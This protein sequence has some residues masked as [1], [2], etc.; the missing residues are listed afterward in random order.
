MLNL[1]YVTI[2]VI[3]A[4][5]QAQEFEEVPI[6]VLSAEVN[7]VADW[8]IG[9]QFNVSILLDEFI[10]PN[11]EILVRAILDPRL[12]PESLGWGEPADDVIV[13]RNGDVIELFFNA[14]STTNEISIFFNAY[15]PNVQ[16]LTPR[17]LTELSVWTRRAARG[18]SSPDAPIR[19]YE[20]C[21]TQ[22]LIAWT[23][24]D[25][26]SVAPRSTEEILDY[27]DRN[28][29]IKVTFFVSPTSWGD[30]F[31]PE[32][33]RVARRMVEEGHEV[34]SHSWS[35]PDFMT[36]TNEEIQEE[37]E[38]TEEFIRACAGTIP[39]QFRPPY[40]SLSK[41]QAEFITGLGY[42]ISLWNLDSFDIENVNEFGTIT[43]GISDGSAIL[44]GNSIVLL[45]H[46][47][48]S[49]DIIGELTQWLQDEYV[50][51]QG[52][53]FTSASECYKNCDT[54]VEGGICKDLG[55]T[56]WMLS[57]WLLPL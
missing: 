17:D 12:S 51:K 13:I 54:I 50:I 21:G 35:H 4:L 24:D 31:L 27:L 23:F 33:C 19:A 56:H 32:K 3:L 14:T 47:R 20:S 37:L 46:D 30:S 39:T 49:Y 42:A 10:R 28:G 38:L 48:S 29:D 57:E 8:E 18:R 26:P 43:Q 22:K 45:S 44:N 5:S 53:E 34:Q 41:D 7:I 2:C 16:P 11:Q 15:S 6:G 36:L 9:G 55:R 52:Y 40:G 25:G 1:V